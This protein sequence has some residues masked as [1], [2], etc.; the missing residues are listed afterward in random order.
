MTSRIALLGLC[1]SISLSAT[2]ADRLVIRVDDAA[3][4]AALPRTLADHPA[5]GNLLIFAEV[6]QDIVI[7]NLRQVRLLNIHADRIRSISFPDLEQAEKIVLRGADMTTASFPSL[8]KVTGSFYVTS[9]ALGSISL[10][11]LTSVGDLQIVGNQQLQQISADRLFDVGGVTIERNPKHSPENVNQL[12]V[13]GTLVT[14]AER[15]R[16]IQAEQ[17]YRAEKVQSY[18]AQR[19]SL[20][21]TGHATHFGTIGFHQDRYGYP[22]WRHYDPRFFPSITRYLFIVR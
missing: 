17:D 21:P 5:I 2:A 4:L 15:R 1:L 3:Q 6:D 9:R 14:R 19:Q 7:P 8:K 13:A 20:P 10:P 11:S 22:H 16:M 12:L 18:L